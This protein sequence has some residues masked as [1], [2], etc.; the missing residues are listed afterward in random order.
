MW[1]DNGPQFAADEFAKFLGTWGI[2][3]GTSSPHYA[4]SNGTA[5]AA[6]KQVKKLIA[7]SWTAGSFDA[8][9]FGKGLLLFRNAP[10]SGGRSPAQAV[11]GSPTRDC[12]PAHHRSFAPEWQ[13]TADILEK[14]E[15]RSAT[16]RVEHYNRHAHPLPDLEV[17][18]RVLIQDPITKCWSTPGVVIEI[19]A[20]RDFLIKTVA[21]RIFRRN[22]RFLRRCIPAMP[23]HQPPAAVDAQPPA[24]PPPIAD[25][26]AQPV[27]RIDPT[28][29]R[30]STRLKT[31]STRYPSHTWAQ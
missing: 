11:F 21:G 7:G 26:A 18:N 1:S 23:T 4:Q 22:R 25:P 29:P 28:P 2:A 24:V 30:Q 8:D 9:K 16:L 27:P 17:G 15:R 14:R 5:E 12:L 13:K 31:P 3:H 20:N 6:I 19:G 10:H